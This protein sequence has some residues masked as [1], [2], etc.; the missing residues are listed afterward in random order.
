VLREPFRITLAKLSR[1]LNGSYDKVTHSGLAK[2]A[3]RPWP[4]SRDGLHCRESETRPDCPND[5]MVSVRPL[6][7]SFKASIRV[8]ESKKLN[9]GGNLNF[10]AD[11]CYS[12]GMIPAVEKAIL[13]RSEINASFLC[14]KFKKS[15]APE[16][17]GVE[18][19]FKVT[20]L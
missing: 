20:I 16:Q 18:S 15:I 8:M 6:R 7:G 13:K 11:L 10:A 17:S 3:G 9:S 1:K 4:A 19:D 5:L 12:S 14:L 2:S